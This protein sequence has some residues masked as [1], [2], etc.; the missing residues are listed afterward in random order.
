[1]SLKKEKYFKKN[2]PNTA[3]TSNTAKQATSTVVEALILTERQ[4]VNV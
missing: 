2:L 3:G 1:M 4:T